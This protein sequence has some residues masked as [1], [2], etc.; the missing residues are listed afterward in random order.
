VFYV[1]YTG[2]EAVAAEVLMSVKYFVESTN[3]WLLQT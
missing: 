3:G 1:G 2:D